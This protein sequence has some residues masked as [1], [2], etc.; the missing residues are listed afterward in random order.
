MKLLRPA[1]IAMAALLAITPLLPQ[2]ARRARRPRGKAAAGS[3][4]RPALCNYVPCTEVLPVRRVLGNARASCHTSRL[5][6]GNGQR[7]L[8]GYVVLSTDVTD[9]PA[10]SGKPVITLIGPTPQAATSPASRSSSTRTH[11]AARHPRVG[12][13]QVQRPIPG[14]V[15][16][17]QH[18][19]RP[20]TPGRGH[21]RPR[22]HLGCHG[23]G[24][25]TEPGHDDVGRRSGASGRHPGEN[26]SPAGE[27]R[28]P[29][30][31][32]RLGDAGRGRPGP[33]PDRDAPSR[34]ASSAARIRS[35]TCGTAT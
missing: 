14:Q 15:R 28:R 23:D 16:R 4:Y 22:R 9:T 33:A 11:P 19:D 6:R 34:S 12:T 8:V 27:I 10:Y 30:P 32:A 26:R 21:D 2:S 3:Q 1:G 17:R 25:R 29:R 20:P 31:Q 35:S 5:R 18:R 24:H 7:K 13:H